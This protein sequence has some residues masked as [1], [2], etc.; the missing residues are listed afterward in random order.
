MFTFD[1]S[2]VNMFTKVGFRKLP[3]VALILGTKLPAEPT[4]VRTHSMNCFLN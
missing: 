3:R 1:K 4:L 2:L